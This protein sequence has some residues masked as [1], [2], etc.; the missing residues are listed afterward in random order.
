M[1]YALPQPR[2][3]KVRP[4]VVTVAA[5]L[6]YVFAGVYLLGELLTLI[7]GEDPRATLRRSNPDLA[8]SDGV[9]TAA[10]V[11]GIVFALVVV[12]ASVVLAIFVG[13]GNNVARIITWSLGGLWVLCN[14]CSVA[15]IGLGSAVHVTD[16]QTGQDIFADMRQQTTVLDIAPALVSLVLLLIALV[17]L[18]LPAAN[19]FFRK[20]AQVWVP[21]MGYAGP[22][23]AFPPLPPATWT[24]PP[25]DQ[26]PPAPPA[27]GQP[28]IP[29]SDPDGPSRP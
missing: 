9:V 26:L 15:V 1:S 4:P 3:A 2:P 11:I 5:V 28:P 18:T 19:D 22:M 24:A 25:S 7:F 21:P 13:R 17:L 23:P 12:A 10:Q 8:V 27:T 20:Q 16:P 29:P 6:L 14:G